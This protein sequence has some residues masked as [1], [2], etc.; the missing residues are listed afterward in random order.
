MSHLLAGRVVAL[1]ETR[2]LDRLAEMLEAEGAKTW[3]CPMVAIHDAPD[4]VPVE[5]WLRQLVAGNFDDVIFL[6]GEGLRRLM[7]V[8][9]A[10]QLSAEVI[11]ALAAVRKIT[12]G[13]KPA[14]ALKEIGL[15]TDLPA[16][17]PTSKGIIEELRQLDLHG[18][19]VGL[20]LYGEDPGTELVS[21]IRASGARV[22]TVSPYVYAPASDANRIID[23]IR[24]LDAGTVD[25]IAFTSASQVD[26]LFDVARAAGIDVEL[27]RALGRACVAA[28][29]PIAVE[30]LRSKGVT[31][32][33]VPEKAF[34]MKRLVAAIAA[35]AAA[36]P[37]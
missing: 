31:A 12:R 23:L 29:G 33:V 17:V 7:R 11:T 9:E 3:R 30:A 19:R 27:G 25:T 34:V 24:G 32:S 2:E 6:T 37:P 15:P 36:S 18:R 16:A 10:R 13:P 5:A 14:R 26:R 22:Q 1:P 4:P 20:Q 35:A 8:A 28:I 21:F